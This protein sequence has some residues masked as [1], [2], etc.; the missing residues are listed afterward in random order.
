LDPE[1][2]GR[3]IK[4][5]MVKF[6]ISIAENLRLYAVVCVV[7]WCSVVFFDFLCWPIMGIVLTYP[8]ACMMNLRVRTI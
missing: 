1:D 2:N 5:T 3:I 8:V 7:K 4:D 6:Q